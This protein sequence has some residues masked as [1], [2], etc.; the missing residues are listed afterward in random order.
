MSG[1]TDFK[2]AAKAAGIGTSTT[3]KDG[4]DSKAAGNVRKADKTAAASTPPSK[5][6]ID[7]TFFKTTQTPEIKYINSKPCVLAY[8]K[9]IL[10]NYDKFRKNDAGEDGIARRNRFDQLITNLESIKG[11]L[12][13]PKELLS[14]WDFYK[15]E[16]IG[17][18]SSYLLNTLKDTLKIIFCVPPYYSDR[19]KHNLG[20]TAGAYVDTVDF[21]DESAWVNSHLDARIAFIKKEAGIAPAP[22]F[23]I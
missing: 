17:I 8:L 21:M 23:I 22:Q 5:V 20:L 7:C 4:K 6:I 10:T 16:S 12:L 18:W 14:I 2:S 3:S 13:G 19:C 1:R 9:L 11:N 15:T